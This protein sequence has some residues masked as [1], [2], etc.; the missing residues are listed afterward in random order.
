MT[1]LSKSWEIPLIGPASTLTVTLYVIVTVLVSA[2]I[3][4]LIKKKLKKFLSSTWTL[5]MKML[6]VILIIVVIAIFTPILINLSALPAVL[7]SI[8]VFSLILFIKKGFKESWI[9]YIGENLAPKNR[10]FT[11]IDQNHYG[12]VERKGGGFIRFLYDKEAVNNDPSRKDKGTPENPGKDAFVDPSQP[13]PN[14]FLIRWAEEA[15]FRWIGFPWRAELKIYVFEWETIH[16][17]AEDK[18][19][20]IVPHKEPI[21]QTRIN[22]Y[23]AFPILDLETSDGQTIGFILRGSLRIDLPFVSTY[24]QAP[25]EY[26]RKVHTEI[27]NVAISYANTRSFVQAKEESLTLLDD[28]LK[29]NEASSSSGP[30]TFKEMTGVNIMDIERYDII[31]KVSPEMSAARE[32]LAIAAAEGLAKVQEEKNAEINARIK[33]ANERASSEI[34]TK[35]MQEMAKIVKDD[36]NM[37]EV[38]TAQEISNNMP[39]LKVL[40]IGNAPPGLNVGSLIDDKNPKNKN[41]QSNQN[42]KK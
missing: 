41:S 19:K 37:K 42:Q 10:L 23:Y 29:L 17:N 15:G 25:G 9:K 26:L 39:E 34:D 4:L 16:P 18:A 6:D 27:R 33:T 38:V 36:P 32:K 31:E 5:I 8:I 40:I 14:F 28:I 7:L 11:R 22:A 12:I 35:R 30:E 3:A 1:L 21:S 13:L 20:A 2:F 24:K